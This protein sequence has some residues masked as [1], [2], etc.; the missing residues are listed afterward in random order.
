MYPLGLSSSPTSGPVSSK[1]LGFDFLTRERVLNVAIQRSSSKYVL[2]AIVIMAWLSFPW[3]F[4]NPYIQSLFVGVG[5]WFITAIGYNI[6]LGNTGQFSFGHGAF[7]GIGAYVTC[8]LYVLLGINYWCSFLIALIVTGFIGCLVA[9][10]AIRLGTFYLA[11]ATVAFHLIFY[12]YVTRSS[13]VRAEIGFKVLRPTFGSMAIDSDLKYFYVVW[14][15]AFVLLFFARNLIS[16]KFGRMLKAVQEDEVAAAT[17]GINV[18]YAKL[19]VFTLSAI[20][21]AITGGLMGPYLGY[22]SP[23][24]YDPF[25]SITILMTVIIGGLGSIWG[26]LLGTFFM[27]LLPEAIRFLGSLPFITPEMNKII[28]HDLFRHL[29]FSLLLFFCIAYLPKGI[30][31]LISDRFHR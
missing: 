26:S 30:A 6:V 15:I 7:V 4:K 27:I 5:M 20:F 17:T 9:L 14:I 23:H 21:A 29:V 22:L 24:A 11:I 25:L 31:G 12:S 18:T 8:C 10:I 28:T 1:V 19:S 2:T 3:L 13:L 16:S